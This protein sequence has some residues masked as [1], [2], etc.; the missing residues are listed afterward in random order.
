MKKNNVRLNVKKGVI[1]ATCTVA[2]LATISFPAGNTCFASEYTNEYAEQV[3]RDNL[4]KHIKY[5][6]ARQKLEVI[7][8][9]G[10]PPDETVL[11]VEEKK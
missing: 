10:P 8:R 3:E 9:I 1:F 6:L 7:N 2:F 4:E 5:E 11:V